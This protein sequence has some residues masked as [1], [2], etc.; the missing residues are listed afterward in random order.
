MK[1]WVKD[2]IVYQIYPRS[3]KDSNNDGIGDINGVRSKLDYLQQLGINTL[4]LSPVYDSPCDDN[5]Y[6]IRDYQAILAEFGTMQDFDLLLEECH[7]R[8]MKLV[9]DLVINHC[10]DEHEWFE[11]SK[12][13]KTGPYADY[14]YWA[15]EPNDLRSVFGGSAWEYC[16][17]RQQFY[18]HTFSKKQPDLNWECSDLVSE[19]EQMVDW[20]LDKGVD[21]FRVDA[22][23]FLD[24]SG[25]EDALN[26]TF[27]TEACVNRPKGHA[28]L[29]KLMS[30]VHTRDV[31]SVG[32]INA[33]DTNELLDY[34]LPSRNEFQM[35]IVF[36]PPEIEVFHENLNQYYKE[37]V[38]TRI[39]VQRQGAWNANFLSNHDKPRQISLYGDDGEFWL[40]SAKAL[41]VLNLTQH[42]TPYLYQGEEIGMTNCY[43]DEISDY[44]DI[45]TVAKYQEQLEHGLSSDEALALVSKAS[46]DNS[47]TPMQWDDSTFAGFSETMPWLKVNENKNTINVKAQQQD[48][49]SILH[50]YQQLIELRLSSETLK[51]GETSLYDTEDAL[52]AY[53]R[54]GD[55]CTYSVIVNLSPA[56]VSA[57]NLPELQSAEL[58]LGEELNES[59]A[60]YSFAIYKS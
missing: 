28:H 9:M 7:Q 58:I 47:R 42:G 24:K 23:S 32:E 31:L 54:E 16:E 35:A 20:W 3:F 45:D 44:D 39:E 29:S 49:E 1:N 34:V 4:W 25:I 11:Q 30:K 46:R 27:A 37:Q 51:T 10:S 48:A 33:R 52:I 60:P 5:G 41:A 38:K 14:F 22:I 15:D 36:T 18:L 43:F 21:G 26:G 6:D 40:Q 53:Q 57:P 55:N 56:R 19:I 2:A 13:S 17:S 12:Q 59:L 8:G 50:F